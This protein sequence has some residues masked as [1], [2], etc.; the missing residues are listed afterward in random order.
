MMV[1]AI[2]GGLPIAQWIKT[3]D[4]EIYSSRGLRPNDVVTLAPGESGQSQL[5]KANAN[6]CNPATGDTSATPGEVGQS[7]GKNKMKK[8]KSSNFPVGGIFE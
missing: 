6:E 5:T 8:E 1:D 4:G 7:H 3:E 2:A